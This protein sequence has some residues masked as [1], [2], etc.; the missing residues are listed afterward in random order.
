MLRSPLLPLACAMALVGGAIPAHAQP[1][2]LETE[3]VAMP[4]NVHR[5]QPRLSWLAGVDR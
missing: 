3:G 2:G 1:T 5:E 4:L